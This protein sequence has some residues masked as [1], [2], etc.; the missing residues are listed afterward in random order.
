MTKV[1]KSLFEDENYRKEKARWQGAE[2]Q[3]QNHV[4]ARYNKKALPTTTTTTTS[5]TNNNNNNNNNN[6]TT[7]IAL[8]TRAPPAGARYV[9]SDDTIKVDLNQY[10][11]LQ[12]VVDRPVVPPTNNF[13]VRHI[14]YE[15]VAQSHHDQGV[16]LRVTI[17]I[18]LLTTQWNTIQLLPDKIALQQVVLQSPTTGMSTQTAT[19]RESEREPASESERERESVCVCE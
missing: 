6:A 16:S 14:K 15:A 2:Q 3:H 10:L 18:S 13:I 4:L 1:A 17:Q 7:I 9:R 5:T 8:Q 19:D 12:R 11:R